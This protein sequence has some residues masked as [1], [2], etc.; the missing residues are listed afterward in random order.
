MVEAPQ[1]EGVSRNASEPDSVSLRIQGAVSLSEMMKP[2]PVVKQRAI[3]T[4]GLSGV[5]GGSGHRQINRGTWEVRSDDGLTSNFLRESITEE[6]SVRKSE[7]RIVVKKRSNVRGAKGPCCRRGSRLEH[8]F[9]LECKLPQDGLNSRV[10]L[11]NI[12]CVR[13]PSG[14]RVTHASDKGRQESRMREICTSGLRRG[15]APASAGPFLLYPLCV[16]ISVPPRNTEI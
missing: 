15:R 2:I 8:T 1:D 7:G 14:F 12:V 6:G 4:I 3:A 16:E 10:T 5:V 13:R 9:N 11:K